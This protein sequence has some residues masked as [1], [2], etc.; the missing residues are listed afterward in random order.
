MKLIRPGSAWP[1]ALM[2][3]AESRVV[4]RINVSPWEAVDESRSVSSCCVGSLRGEVLLSP[5]SGGHKLLLHVGGGN[6]R[7]P[8][9]I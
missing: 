9:D 7:M 6:V 1:K 8:A 3:K 2:T 4:G 5:S